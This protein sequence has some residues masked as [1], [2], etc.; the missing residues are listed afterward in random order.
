MYTL[1]FTMLMFCN[2]LTLLATLSHCPGCKTK[3][4]NIK[5][6][7]AFFVYFFE[8]CF[9]KSVMANLLR[10]EDYSSTGSPEYRIRI[11][12]NKNNFTFI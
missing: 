12:R 3:R 11:E 10:P 8:F 2:A 6:N 5:N 4:T 9:I 1:Y 7:N